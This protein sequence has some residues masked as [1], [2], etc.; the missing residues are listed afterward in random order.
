M[1]DK[2]IKIPRTVSIADKYCDNCNKPNWFFYDPKVKKVS[3]YCLSCQQIKLKKTFDAISDY[4][5]LI[6]Q[7]NNNIK[8][9]IGSKRA[10]ALKNYLFQVMY[11]VI[12]DFFDNNIPFSRFLKMKDLIVSAL[13]Y[14][15]GSDFYIEKKEFYDFIQNVYEISNFTE[16]IRN[17]QKKTMKVDVQGGLYYSYGYCRLQD[18][19]REFG[20]GTRNEVQKKINQT[21]Y[22][23]HPSDLGSSKGK[24]KSLMDQYLERDCTSVE[25]TNQNISEVPV[26][27]FTAYCFSLNIYNSTIHNNDV[28][29]YL[30]FSN[31]TQVK[32]NRI[33]TNN[34]GIHLK[35]SNLCNITDNHIYNNSGKGIYLHYSFIET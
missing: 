12:T 25:V 20:M 15:K 10:I 6:E 1:F 30:F 16:F 11:L 31:Q 2:E 7:Y 22:N 14:S 13:R 32:S 28:G 9:L 18:A 5:I 27:L 21:S 23:Y 34:E 29:I 8:N 17:I 24:K 26:G 4:Q 3:P 33:F 35:H 19:L